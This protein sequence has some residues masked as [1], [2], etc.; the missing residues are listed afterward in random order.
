MWYP[1]GFSTMGDWRW[2]RGSNRQ[3]QFHIGEKPRALLSTART[4]I[5]YSRALNREGGSFDRRTSIPCV[6]DAPSSTTSRP[7][8]SKRNLVSVVQIF[9]CQDQGHRSKRTGCRWGSMSPLGMISSAFRC[10]SLLLMLIPVFSYHVS[11][12]SACSDHW[13]FFPLD[14]RLPDRISCSRSYA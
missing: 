10:V 6:I 7:C 4:S 11:I 1:R 13:R 2:K 8:L 9:R 3:R 14:I 12:Y 5:M